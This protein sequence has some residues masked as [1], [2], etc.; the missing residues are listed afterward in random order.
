MPTSS[1]VSASAR[2][3]SATKPEPP[4][5]ASSTAPPLPARSPGHA[6]HQM[7]SATASRR[8]AE[9]HELKPTRRD[10]SIGATSTNPRL[11]SGSVIAAAAQRS[12]LGPRNP[13]DFASNESQDAVCR[14]RR[15][16][17]PVV[18]RAILR[19]R[20]YKRWKDGQPPRRYTSESVVAAITGAK[21]HL[22]DYPQRVLESLA[23]GATFRSLA[24]KEIIVYANESHVS[25]G[26]V[27]LLYGQLEERRP[28]SGGGKPK[29][30]SGTASRPVCTQ[31]RRLH[32]A[33][34]VLCLMPVMCEDRATSFLSTREHE[35]AD[36]AIIP[37]RWFWEVTYNM[38]HASPHTAVA[39]GRTLREVVL[40]HRHDMLLAEYFPTSAVLLRSWMWSLLTPSDRVKLCRSMEVRVLSVGDVLFEEGGYCPYIYVVRRGA[41]T[42][43]VKGEA[44]AVVEAGAAMGE[45]SVLFH[46]RRSSTV[47][48]ATVCELYALHVRHLLHRFLKYPER[49]HHIIA[50]ALERQARWMEEGRA[51]DVF[52]LVSILSGVPCLGHTTDAMR[53]EMAQCAT[54][55]ILPHGHTLTSTHAPCTFFCVIGRGSVTLTSAIKTTAVAEPPPATNGSAREGGSPLAG[56][57]ASWG[58]PTPALPAEVRREVRSAGDFFGELC[59]KPHLWPYEVVCDS[60]VSLWSFDR[61]AVLRVLEKHRADAQAIE[62]CRQGISLYRAQ[63]G[64]ASIVECFDAPATP[65]APAN[66]WHTRAGS[67]RSRALSTDLTMA[68]PRVRSNS[69][70]SRTGRRASLSQHPAADGSSRGTPTECLAPCGGIRAG[71]EWSPEQWTAYA[72]ARLQ[73][74]LCAESEKGC[75]L[76]RSRD[77]REVDKEVE[78]TLNE[79]VLQLVAVQL[80]TPPSPADCDIS[81]DPGELQSI[82]VEQ[83]FLIV[84]VKQPRFLRQVNDSNVRLVTDE[85]ETPAMGLQNDSLENVRVMDTMHNAE[86]PVEVSEVKQL[87]EIGVSP[88]AGSQFV[89]QRAKP[90]PS[91]LHSA[92]VTDLISVHQVDDVLNGEATGAAQTG[93][94]VPSTSLGGP[95]RSTSF[96]AIGEASSVF[97][98]SINPRTSLNRSHFVRPPSGMPPSPRCAS[99]RDDFL[100]SAAIGF[101]RP[102]SS[103][104]PRVIPPVRA[105][106]TSVDFNQFSNKLSVDRSAS[107]LDRYVKIE[108]QNYFDDYVKVLPL[109]PDEMWAPD[110]V[111]SDT[112]M[113]TDSMILLLLHVLKCDNLSAEAMQR[114]ARPIVKV[115][116]GQ[117]ALV[118]TSVMD[119]CTAPRWAIE[120]SSFIS[121]VRRGSEIVFSVCDA[122]DESR[123]VYQTS[124]PAASIHENGGVGR[125]VMSLKEISMSGSPVGTNLDVDVNSDEDDGGSRKD[126]TKPHVTVTMLAVTAF[127]YKA[128][129]QYLEA[130]EKAVVGSPGPP[131]S[132]TLF[133]QVMSVEGLRHRIEATITV[134]LYN[135]G[136]TRKLLETKRVK[137]KTRSP[138][139]PGENGFATVSSDGGVLTFDLYHKDSVIGS[140][141]ATVDELIFGGVGLRRLPLL[142]AQTGRLVIGDLVVAVLGA[143]LRDSFE[144][145]NRDW[146]THLAVEGLS[147]A[148]EG[149]SI[150][151]DPFIVL[152]DGTGAV[153]MRTPLAFS[154]FEA[155]W[156]M[157][158]ASCLLQCPRLCGSTVSYQLEV[159]DSDEKEVLG[160]AAIVLGDRGLGPGHRHNIALDPPGRGLVR[161]RSL[162]LPVL[163]LPARG[164]VYRA[165]MTATALVPPSSF[166]AQPSEP[167]TLLLL[168]VSGCA[169]LPGGASAELQ[170][171]A[172]GT[173][174][175]DSVPYLRTSLQEAT[176]A[177]RWPFS[178]ASVLL[179]IPSRNDGENEA[180]A[181]VDHQQPQHC[182]ECRFAVY[183]GFVDNVSLIGQVAVPLSQLLNSA[184]HAYPLFPRCRDADR[185]AMG[186]QLS[187]DTTTRARVAAERTVGC[188]HVFT[189]LGSLDHQVCTLAEQGPGAPSAH[190]P[191]FNP[192]S[193]GGAA[194]TSA[195]SALTSTV[196]L[197]VSNLCD[198]LP[199]ASEKYVRLV[200]RDGATVLLSV[201]RQMG[202]LSHAEWGPTDACAAVS[203]AAFPP[204]GALEV[205]LTAMNVVERGS[206]EEDSSPMAGNP[207][208]ESFA[209]GE[210]RRRSVLNGRGTAATLFLGRAELPVSRLS[211]VEAGEVQVVTLMLSV[212]H[213][214]ASFSDTAGQRVKVVSSMRATRDVREA[215]P[216][217]SFSIFGNRA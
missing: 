52:G 195:S 13:I 85:A 105:R 90:L 40:P 9:M 104:E 74:G 27:V 5:R 136:T 81:G 91:V 69:A 103:S 115:T 202:V 149:F 61:D 138:A 88:L 12:S 63:R 188:I 31:T 167:A 87:E 73:E 187:L 191:Y 175:I 43:I 108:D 165:S 133:L 179:R 89:S 78:K 45:E 10:S 110:E 178:K 111:A 150:T 189:L 66:G 67:Q 198:I 7:P 129:R 124:L 201:E 143:R 94:P 19:C 181:G 86:A 77:L 97:A 2:R 160:R 59:L 113:G 37:S 1:Q 210:V 118:R 206:E 192:D 174:S 53:E 119:N 176:T 44:L 42:A 152:R 212:A 30:V 215:L 148:R 51:R 168:H 26:I 80:E 196:V 18:M 22:T 75:P 204:D 142:Q 116:L 60:T 127:K 128:L 82:I 15:L 213:R 166:H 141:E 62:V 216:A 144:N 173:F 177:P 154:A 155:S 71:V 3:V 123:I 208:A 199:S 70:G 203:C 182:H 101:T 24:P 153:Q 6:L 16:F 64:E 183:D 25:C 99:G 17:L 50:A 34:S 121:F 211:S 151:P 39:I 131:E 130:R 32:K 98:A 8:S 139:W 14:L 193:A 159:C 35:E 11:R 120:R 84:T 57:R 135:G 156:T 38:T 126:A 93:W 207:E 197:S 132:T 28:E 158:E 186:T 137:P 109:K 205:E 170:T 48:A 114:C 79:K 102:M 21:S 163:E 47:V 180:G 194:L 23:E 41:L 185:C 140:T 96:G 209:K 146:V 92:D 100:S 20:R 65:N 162:C 122:D 169:D 125:R 29:G 200:V 68:P 117:R 76:T 36:V 55:L 147:L 58:K 164:A 107:L 145:R 46:D 54:V 214:T 49:A 95:R 106:P 33:I 217:V 184:L 56:R 171:D 83:L 134:S 157:F 72:I 172:I 4:P 112:E 161:L 190:L